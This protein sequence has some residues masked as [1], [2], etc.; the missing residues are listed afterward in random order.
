MRRSTPSF[1]PASIDTTIRYGPE[2]RLPSFDLEARA[3]VASR[4]CVVCDQDPRRQF[5]Q[6]QLRLEA[7]PTDDHS[8]VGGGYFFVPGGAAGIGDWVGSGLATV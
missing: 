8:P 7:E 1:P 2:R 3:V 5:E 4:C 6:I